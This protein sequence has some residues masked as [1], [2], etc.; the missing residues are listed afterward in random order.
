MPSF[1]PLDSNCFPHAALITWHPLQP[2]IDQLFYMESWLDQHVGHTSWA[3]QSFS[4]LQSFYCG[5]SFAH[6]HDQV[7]FLLRWAEGVDIDVNP[8]A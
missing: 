7:L 1:T 5:V 8:Q 2:W 6:P 4:L 3:W